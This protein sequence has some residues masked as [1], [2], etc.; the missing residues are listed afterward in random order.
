MIEIM[1]D[2]YTSSAE[3]ADIYS[4]RSKRFHSPPPFSVISLHLSDSNFLPANLQAGAN[5][6]GF[7]KVADSIIEQGSF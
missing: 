4:V 7:L 3:A 1:D 2:I 6:A 5:I